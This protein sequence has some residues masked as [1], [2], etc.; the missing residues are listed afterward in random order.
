MGRGS[1]KGKKNKK[2]KN[3]FLPFLPFLQPLLIHH[4]SLSREYAYN[5]K[6]LGKDK[7]STPG[8]ARDG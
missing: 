4:P 1:K 5:S 7:V 6:D 3:S 8:M 2:G